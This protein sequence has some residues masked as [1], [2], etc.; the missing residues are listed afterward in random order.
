MFNAGLLF[1]FLFNFLTAAKGVFLGSFLQTVNPFLVL[2]LC[3]G[4][5]TLFFIIYNR[6]V[7]GYHATLG[8][9][10]RSHWKQ[11]FGLNLSALVGWTGF[12]FALKLIEP[13]IVT[14]ITSAS[15]PILT[16]IYFASLRKEKIPSIQWT[17]YTTTAA[18]MVYL[19]IESYLGF[20]AVRDISIS[21]VAIGTGAAL[22]CGVANVANAVLAKDLNNRGLKARH[23]IPLR[24][25]LLVIA[26][27]LLSPSTAWASLAHSDVLLSIL[28]I[29][30]FGVAIPVILF[31]KGIEYTNPFTVASVHATIPIFVLAAQLFDQ[32]LV[33]SRYSIIGAVGITVISMLSLIIKSAPQSNAVS[34]KA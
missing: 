32:R 19:V 10:T 16:A 29:A 8:A 31:Q 27:A 34:R 17:F 4:I 1:L 18:V 25:Y 24:F 2:T 6:V 33:P 30:F 12:Y 13:A 22:S 15:G 9:Q 5:V 11:I 23:I 21:Q 3:F 7:D 28:V 26:G 14:S 20:S